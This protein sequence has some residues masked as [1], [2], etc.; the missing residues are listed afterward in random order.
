MWTSKV[1]NENFN[2]QALDA[3]FATEASQDTKREEQT[4]IGR[5]PILFE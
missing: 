3:W 5:F 2:V 4:A 1:K